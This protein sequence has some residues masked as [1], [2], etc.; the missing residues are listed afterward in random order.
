MM[1]GTAE[2]LIYNILH[3]AQCVIVQAL[4]LEKQ[5]AF[6]NE[7]LSSK[8][9]GVSRSFKNREHEKNN[10]LFQLTRIAAVSKS[11]SYSKPDIKTIQLTITLSNG[12]F[13]KYRGIAIGAILISILLM[14]VSWDNTTEPK[15]S[16]YKIIFQTN[17]RQGFLCISFAN[18]N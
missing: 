15:K 1:Y 17:R 7:I 5:C 18:V 14:S 4:V 3:A 8:S 13:Y 2:T 9:V 10:L 16:I 12:S 6:A 11:D